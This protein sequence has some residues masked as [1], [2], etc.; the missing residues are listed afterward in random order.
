MTILRNCDS[1]QNTSSTHLHGLVLAVPPFGSA[2]GLGAG[3]SNRAATPALATSQVE[4]WGEEK[5][6]KGCSSF[7]KA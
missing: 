7:T 5:C 4:K 6:F 2:P 3:C 1:V